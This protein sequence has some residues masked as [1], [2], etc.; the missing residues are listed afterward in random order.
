M[1][2]MIAMLLAVMMVLSLMACGASTPQDNAATDGDAPVVTDGATLGEGTHSFTL[3]IVDE[4]KTVTA[5]IHTNKETVGAALVEL[6]IIQG[7]DSSYGMYIKSVNGV[8]ADYE[9]DQTYWAFYVD[10]AYAQTGVDMTAIEEGSVYRL[11][12]ERA[13]A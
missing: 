1:K 7:E 13:Q 6:N 12:I 9:K 10:G 4:E 2:K 5:T 11:A 8:T 3:E